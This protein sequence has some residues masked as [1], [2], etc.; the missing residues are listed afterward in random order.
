MRLV[1]FLASGVERIGALVDGDRRIVDFAAAGGAD[2]AFA[3]M[4]ALIE[5]G[6]E[7]PPNEKPTSEL[8]LAPNTTF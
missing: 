8:V 4:Q 7:P 5:G 2:S 1:T 3:G 6:S